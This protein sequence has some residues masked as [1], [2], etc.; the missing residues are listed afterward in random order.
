MVNVSW[1]MEHRVLGPLVSP[2]SLSD[3]FDV[4]DAVVVVSLCDGVGEAIFV[5]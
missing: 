5:D 3:E 1:Q 2:I 4:V